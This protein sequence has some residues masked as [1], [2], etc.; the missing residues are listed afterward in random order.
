MGKQVRPARPK[1]IWLDG[2]YW[3]N[4]MSFVKTCIQLFKIHFAVYNPKQIRQILLTIL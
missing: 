1:V 3:D 2:F 4:S